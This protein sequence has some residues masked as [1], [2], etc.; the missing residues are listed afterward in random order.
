MDEW[1]TAAERWLRS[2]DAQGTEL[3]AAFAALAERTARLERHDRLRTFT[4][5]IAAAS[6]RTAPLVSVVMPTRDRV[7]FLPRAIASVL[8]Q[9][10][11]NFELLVVDDGSVEDVRAVVTDA[12]DERVRCVRTEP[13]GVC[14]ARNAGLD[15]ATGSIVAYLDDDNIMDE[16]WLKAIVWAFEQR[17]DV[18]VV[19]G[20]L[21]IDDTA[22]QHGVDG[23]ELPSLW[24]H[25]FDR[26]ALAERNL[27]D[28]GTIA[29]RA[30]IAG[31]RFDE[32]LGRL[33]DWDM[34]LS[35]SASTDPLALPVVACRYHTDAPNRLSDRR[36]AD[37]D[38]E[39]MRHKHGFGA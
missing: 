19:F 38:D 29:H 30:G 15:E 28:A 26:A 14:A 12:K 23:W 1:R 25:D 5:W 21:M 9:R 24:V 6:L 35:L 31:A 18:E 20:A 27:A 4:E 13:R 34:L 2:L 39:R 32:S 16:L 3:H 7:T 10:Y 22:T 8:D 36:H 11:A 17:P 33:G 37:A